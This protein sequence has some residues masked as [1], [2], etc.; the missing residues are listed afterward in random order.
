MTRCCCL[1]TVARC[2]SS[3]ARS[4]LPST[5]SCLHDETCEACACNASLSSTLCMCT[6]A[7]ITPHFK[8]SHSPPR[9]F[10]SLQFSPAVPDA[11]TCGCLQ[12]VV[13]KGELRT[14]MD[15]SSLHRTVPVS[16]RLDL[17]AAATTCTATRSCWVSS[18]TSKHASVDKLDG[19][20]H[21]DVIAFVEI[22]EGA[23]LHVPR[24]RA[25]A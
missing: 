24:R 5:Y 17:R 9:F 2:S 18:R 19:R 13:C 12:L 8:A 3:T 11:C 21:A 25:R 15:V 20:S 14:E 4:K 22:A 6:C 10:C 7:S 1:S 16:S 23:P